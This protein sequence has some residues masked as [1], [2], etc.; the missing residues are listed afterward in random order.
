MVSACVVTG[1]TVAGVEGGCESVGVGT[2][3]SVL[4]GVPT[5]DLVTTSA[6]VAVSSGLLCGVGETGTEGGSDDND[7]LPR[8]LFGS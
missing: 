5:V 2:S 7:E 8:I 6:T 4:A 3:S 1:T